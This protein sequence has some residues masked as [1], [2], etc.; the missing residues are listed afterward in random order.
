[1]SRNWNWPLLLDIQALTLTLY[2]PSNF[3]AQ[4]SPVAQTVKNPP[5][6]AGDPCWIPG[7][8]ICPGEG[9]GTPLQYSCWRIPWTEKPG[10]LQSMGSQRVIH[11]WGTNTLPP[12]T[13]GSNGLLYSGWS[14]HYSKTMPQALHLYILTATILGNLATSR[15]FIR[16]SSHY[17]VKS[18]SVSIPNY[19]WKK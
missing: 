11:N 9:K 16:I 10:G 5:A 17:S 19:T 14:T 6:N 15:Q 7:S 3:T 2:W 8:G 12:P 4:Y 18:V 13:Q 1:M